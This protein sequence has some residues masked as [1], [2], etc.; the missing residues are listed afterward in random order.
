MGHFF[1]FLGGHTHTAGQLKSSVVAVLRMNSYYNMIEWCMHRIGILCVM[2]H[3]RRTLPHICFISLFASIFLFLS[4]FR[5]LARPVERTSEQVRIT[6]KTT[7][8]M[9]IFFHFMINFFVF[10][11]KIAFF[12]KF[13]LAVVGSLRYTCS[14]FSFSFN[15][16]YYLP[17]YYTIHSIFKP[18]FFILPFRTS[19]R[20]VRSLVCF[21]PVCMF[22]CWCVLVLYSFDD[23]ARE[24]DR[25][26]RL[27]KYKRKSTVM[28]STEFSFH[29]TSSPHDFFRYAQSSPPLSQRWS[30][31]Q[32]THTHTEKERMSKRFSGEWENREN[33]VA[34]NPTENVV[35][36]VSSSKKTPK[37]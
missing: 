10:E 17:Y 1:I 37:Q 36:C 16:Y 26:V 12:A 22:R 23:F 4:L 19:A 13:A 30:V 24:F 29:V 8:H 28:V 11:Q 7:F 15:D 31:G 18:L 34:R 21:R 9:V 25:Y 35:V 33:M 32:W 14:P 27:H 5:Y 20:L 2:A 6:W 3:F